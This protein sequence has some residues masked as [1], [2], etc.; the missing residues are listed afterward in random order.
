M[1]KLCFKFLVMRTVFRYLFEILPLWVGGI[2]SDS[3][4]LFEC[5]GCFYIT[6]FLSYF[7]L[8]NL[9]FFYRNQTRLLVLF[10]I[11][12]L[13]FFF[14]ECFNQK[15]KRHLINLVNLLKVPGPQSAVWKPRF[16]GI[17]WKLLA[18]KTIRKWRRSSASGVVYH[19]PEPATCPATSRVAR[20]QNGV[21]AAKNPFFIATFFSRKVLFRQFIG[22]II[23]FWKSVESV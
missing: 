18:S 12:Y 8:I 6:T 17:F 5:Q 4:N 19:I 15:G 9:K 14:F 1:M 22:K 7:L 16:V 20:L 2:L 13:W 21:G 11:G 3:L 10:V 23:R